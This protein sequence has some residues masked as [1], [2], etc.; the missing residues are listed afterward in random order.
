MIGEE[1]SILFDGY[2]LSWVNFVML[3]SEY[4]DEGSNSFCGPNA[5]YT[6]CMYIWGRT[7]KEGWGLEGGKREETEYLMERS[8]VVSY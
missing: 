2:F 6:C 1:T 7:L 5:K 3:L 8:E 4:F